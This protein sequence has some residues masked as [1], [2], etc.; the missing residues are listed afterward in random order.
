MYRLHV[1]VPIVAAAGILM[2]PASSAE[3][4]YVVVRDVNIGGF[5]LIGVQA[6]T[7]QRA[8]AVFGPPTSQQP[9]T[10]DKCVAVWRDHGL[11]MELWDSWGPRATCSR[12]ALHW[13]TTLTDS[14]W[15]TSAGLRIGD[16]ARRIRMLYRRAKRQP[17]G[18]AIIFR[19]LAGVRSPSVFAT[20]KDG[21]VASFIVRGPR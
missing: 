10:F 3:P 20:V 4:T 21:R 11:R 1:L 14:R 6:R 16:P 5:S 7:L 9:N 2:V 19:P 18:W 13:E 17:E 12:D 8:I 15:R